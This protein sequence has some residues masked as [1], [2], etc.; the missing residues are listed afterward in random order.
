[1]ERKR[2]IYETI[3]GNACYVAGPQATY[4]YDIDAG[5]KIPMSCVTTKWLR[6]AEPSDRR[7]Q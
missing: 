3:W 7:A 6:K 4:A 1:M 5:E 2:G